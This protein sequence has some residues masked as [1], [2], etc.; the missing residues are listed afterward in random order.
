MTVYQQNSQASFIYHLGY[1]STA[2]H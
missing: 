2:R 1:T